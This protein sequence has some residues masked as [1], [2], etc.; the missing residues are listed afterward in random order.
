[1]VVAVHIPEDESWESERWPSE[2]AGASLV[3]T[4]PDQTSSP[5]NGHLYCATWPA[6]D[7]GRFSISAQSRL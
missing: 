7:W 3:Q 5:A 6:V 2:A 1:M 4:R